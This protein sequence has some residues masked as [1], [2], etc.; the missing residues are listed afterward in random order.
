MVA[1]HLLFLNIIFLNLRHLFI[2]FPQK[3]LN[4]E[5]GVEYTY[6]ILVHCRSIWQQSLYHQMKVDFIFLFIRRIDHL[7]RY[8]KRRIH[9][10][11]Q[12]SCYIN[13]AGRHSQETQELT[14]YIRLILQKR[15][16]KITILILEQIEFILFVGHRILFILALMSLQN[17]E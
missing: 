9:F 3:P 14:G 8:M 4:L 12:D 11:A 5:T 17:S 6:E 7:R 15:A 10:V 16:T 2:S 13:L 1:F